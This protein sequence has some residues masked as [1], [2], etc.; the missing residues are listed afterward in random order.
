MERKVVAWFVW[1][2][3]RARGRP[4][5]ATPPLVSGFSSLKERITKTR[6]KVNNR[7]TDIRLYAYENPGVAA[8]RRNRELRARKPS[9]N[10]KRLTEGGRKCAVFSARR[11][12]ASCG[13]RRGHVPK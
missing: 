2:E 7:T 3:E 11:L 12:S 9:S 4:P 1:Q 8:G 5:V 10:H 6:T 13:T